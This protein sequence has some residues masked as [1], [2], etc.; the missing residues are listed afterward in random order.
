MFIKIAEEQIK[1][2]ELDIT[3]LIHKG[4]N[5]IEFCAT[6]LLD[7]KIGITEY[8]RHKLKKLIKKVEKITDLLEKTQE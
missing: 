5:I 2:F 7:K 3:C 1:Y 6:P 8:E 4:Q